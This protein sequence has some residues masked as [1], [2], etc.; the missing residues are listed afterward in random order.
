MKHWY[1]VGVTS[2][3]MEQA[4]ALRT[5][6]PAFY[7]DLQNATDHQVNQLVYKIFNQQGRERGAKEGGTRKTAEFQTIMIAS[8]EADIR[9]K[10]QFQGFL[11]RS[12]VVTDPVFVLLS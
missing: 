5:H 1:A 11:R 9:E 4:L 7:E 6:M 12:L 2:V 8:A 10:A 3:G